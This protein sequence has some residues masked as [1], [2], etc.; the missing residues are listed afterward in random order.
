[1]L[2]TDIFELNSENE[3]NKTLN[4]CNYLNWDFLWKLPGGYI[5][6]HF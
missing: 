3:W 6:E 5:Y 4:K 1:M 2:I